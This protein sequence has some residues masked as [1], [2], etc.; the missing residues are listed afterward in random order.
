[1]ENKSAP[2][3]AAVRSRCEAPVWRRR[4]PGC[5][6]PCVGQLHALQ[7][8]ANMRV[9]VQALD[10]ACRQVEQCVVTD[11]TSSHSAP[12]RP[13]TIPR[14]P[15]TQYGLPT[16]QAPLEECAPPTPLFQLKYQSAQLALTY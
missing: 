5:S 8:A 16:K 2:P 11:G 15:V 14:D 12:Y 6:R 9:G 4:I 13:P 3:T 10:Y 7:D 1:M